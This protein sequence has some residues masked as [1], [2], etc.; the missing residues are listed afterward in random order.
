V[1]PL[2]YQKWQTEL[3]I[4]TWS[5][6]YSAVKSVVIKVENTKIDHLHYTSVTLVVFN[7]FR[8]E[9]RQGRAIYTNFQNFESFWVIDS[10]IVPKLQMITGKSFKSS[11]EKVQSK[12]S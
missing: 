1:L 8:L 6:Y 4:D 3:N 9:Q 5:N 12:S 2:K 7:A 11:W 10:I